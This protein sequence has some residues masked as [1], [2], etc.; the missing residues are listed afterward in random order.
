MLSIVRS[1]DLV[2]LEEDEHYVS[3]SACSILSKFPCETHQSDWCEY[4]DF[5]SEH[6]QSPNT[7]KFVIST[8]IKTAIQKGRIRIG[9]K[10]LIFEPDALD[11]CI[12]KLHFQHITCIYDCMN[13]KNGVFVSCKQVKAIPSAIYNGKTRFVSAY[14]VHSVKNVSIVLNASGLI[15]SGKCKITLPSYCFV[16]VF[17]N[18]TVQKQ[19]LKEFRN[20]WECFKS[21][22]HVDYTLGNFNGFSPT[23]ICNREKILLGCK[24]AAEARDIFCWRLKRMVR[25]GGFAALS[26]RAVYFQPCPNFSRKLCKRIPLDNILHVF[27]RDSGL[28]NNGEYVTALEIISLPSRAFDSS[29]TA[30][31]KMY[32]CLY[33]EFKRA[34]DREHFATALKGMIPR[35]FYALES[36]T[37]RREM[38]H[39][40][41]RGLIP[42]FQYLD[43]LNCIAGRS[44][45]DLSRYPVFPWVISDYTSSSL[46]LANPRVYRDLSKPAGALNPE[47]LQVLKNRMSGLKLADT[48]VLNVSTFGKNADFCECNIT[49]GMEKACNKCLFNAWNRGY[50]LY[51]CHYS[52]PALIV[53]FL[54]RCFPECQLRLYGGKFD[55]AARTF[56]NVAETFSNVLH[57]H[58]SFFELIPEFYEGSDVFLRNCLNIT[59]QDGR[60]GDVELP[61]WANNSSCQFLKMMRMAL[62]SEH[63][64]KNLPSWI[65]LIFG[66]KQAGIESIRNDNVFH[67]L[68]YLGSVHAGKLPQ[69]KAIQF[70]Q[71]TMDPKAISV[72]VGEFGQ[73]PIILFDAPHPSRLRNFVYK[74]ETGSNN[75]WFI[76]LEQHPELIASTD[77]NITDFKLPRTISQHSDAS[78]LRK[79]MDSAASIKTELLKPSI[80]PTTNI[81][82]CCRN[83]AYTTTARGTCEFYILQKQ[84]DPVSLCIGKEAQTCAAVAGQALLVGSASGILTICN[85]GNIFEWFSTPLND[86]SNARAAGVDSGIHMYRTGIHI[87]TIT[88]LDYLDGILTSGGIDET[89]KQFTL[90]DGAVKMV[91]CYSDLNSPLADVC[92]THDLLLCAG[93]DGTLVLYDTRAPKTS[94]WSVQLDSKRSILSCYMSNLYIQVLQCSE[95]PIVYWD[96]RMLNS[97]TASGGFKRQLNI[98]NFAITGAAC[99]RGNIVA[100]CGS[101]RGDVGDKY[102]LHLVDL[103]SGKW[104]AGLTLEMPEPSLVAV[105]TFGSGYGALVANSRGSLQAIVENARQ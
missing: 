51:G 28:I 8:Q 87:D 85:L 22:V 14:D 58:S 99:D 82:F 50:Y 42:N 61:P 83:V 72:Q 26:D 89:V 95:T 48:D 88:C 67:P 24:G 6:D 94:I 3:D 16:F 98:P 56:K 39:L 81:G 11:S 66:Y 70:L 59:T 90:D 12:L 74:A 78:H 21:N 35:A 27:R 18:E 17:G 57:G 75:P 65:D 53:F 33:I 46:D 41:R 15:T 96:V 19:Q 97:I 7:C 92:G 79:L 30:S 36:R 13:V 102:A 101:I 93:Q 43:F 104:D 37:F 40:W 71:S 45:Y 25:H 52:T 77:Q 73:A 60:L 103:C 69:S 47:R 54:I 38:T 44:R 4:L 34:Q 63:V 10:S 64:S 5:L 32:R 68:S 29:A 1:F 23:L 31:R 84:N 62:E 55:V 100:L 20:L 80:G 9:T 105:D 91:G 76:Y 2:L 86:L 49:E